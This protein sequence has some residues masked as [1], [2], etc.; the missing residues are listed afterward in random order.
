[1]SQR[2][3]PFEGASNAPIAADFSKIPLPPEGAEGEKATQV[4][5][6]VAAAEVAVIE[7]LDPAARATEI[8][9]DFPF[10]WD[11]R[12]IVSVTARR[13]TFAEVMR[14]SEMAPKD[15]DGGIA[16]IHFYAE[17]IGLPAPVI[18]ALDS[19]DGQRVQEGCFPFLP[20]SIAGSISKS[21]G[22]T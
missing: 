6:P 14:V 15:A 22:E 19:D 21:T 18:R 4:E 2:E 7:F 13:L 3:K 9:L 8:P 11:G 20:R 1:M 16:L 10:V 5:K 17:M 12:E